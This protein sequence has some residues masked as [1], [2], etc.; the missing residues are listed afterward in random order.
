LQAR[1]GW[2]QPSLK[3]RSAKRVDLFFTT[4]NKKKMAT[5]VLS[6]LALVAFASVAL[7]PILTGYRGQV[8]G[9]VSGFGFSAEINVDGREKDG[10][11]SSSAGQSGKLSGEQLTKQ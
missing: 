2:F 4:L 5:S 7:T 9:K 3:Q 6:A 1:I 11:L 10:S 8:I